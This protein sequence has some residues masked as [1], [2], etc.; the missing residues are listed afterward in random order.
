MGRSIVQGLKAVLRLLL[1]WR[2]RLASAQPLALIRIVWR[3]L[4]ARVA[5][6]PPGRKRGGGGDLPSSLP[7]G[8]IMRINGVAE[9]INASE[10]P[11]ALPALRNRRSRS[12][13]PL[14]LDIPHS[15]HPHAL[16]SPVSEGGEGPYSFRVENPSEDSFPSSKFTQNRPDTPLS[17]HLSVSMSRPASPTRV[18]RRIKDDRL[19]RLITPSDSRRR[20][21]SH[22]RSRSQTP[23]VSTTSLS[24]TLPHGASSRTSF[25]SSK[26]NVAAPARLLGRDPSRCQTTYPTLETHRYD[27]PE[28]L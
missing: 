8:D 12:P 25:A 5:D 4:L 16:L 21:R 17:E 18:S 26:P 11:T 7:P 19:S 22:N 1:I 15:N 2:H 3:W 23:A 13:S 28:K 20:N 6:R 24:R 14:S 9:V 10:E 27:R